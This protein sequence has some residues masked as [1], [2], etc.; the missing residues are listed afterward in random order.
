M[1]RSRM[2]L[3]IGTLFILTSVAVGVFLRLKKLNTATSPS[4]P[5]ETSRPAPQSLIWN[6]EIIPPGE[7][8]EAP[9]QEYLDCLNDGRMDTPECQE[10]RQ[11]SYQQPRGPYDSFNTQQ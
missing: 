7:F 3:I 1:P 10:A 6:N 4:T 5:L 9:T 8:D 11:R 2:L